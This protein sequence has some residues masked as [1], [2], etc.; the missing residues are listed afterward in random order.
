MLKRVIVFKLLM[1]LQWIRQ[2]VNTLL[3][4]STRCQPDK[5]R[6][7]LRKRQKTYIFNFKTTS[8]TQIIEKKCTEFDNIW[9]KSV[10]LIFSSLFYINYKTTHWKPGPPLIWFIFVHIYSY[11]HA[12]WNKVVNLLKIWAGLW[13]QVNFLKM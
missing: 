2:V 3:G 9:E 10:L 7:F 5:K 1:Y 12:S 8:I 13:K 11:Y 6:L 4:H